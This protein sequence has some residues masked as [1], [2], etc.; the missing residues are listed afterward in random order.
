MQYYSGI[1]KMQYTTHIDLT[2]TSTAE[3][4]LADKQEA[5]A[6]WQ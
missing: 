3:T 6:I 1:I 2:T 5:I 4:A